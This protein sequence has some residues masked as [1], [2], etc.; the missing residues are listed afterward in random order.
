MSISKDNPC[1]LRMQIFLLNQENKKLDFVET[2][3]EKDQL[4][5]KEQAR[6]ISEYIFKDIILSNYDKEYKITWEGLYIT[7]EFYNHESIE[8][9][10]SIVSMLH[11]NAKTTYLS[12]DVTVYKN[13]PVIFDNIMYICN[14]RLGIIHQETTNYVDYWKFALERPVIKEWDLWSDSKEEKNISISIRHN[15][16][17]IPFA[18]E[19][20]TPANTIY[21]DWGDK[22]VAVNNK[23]GFTVGDIVIA[24][25]KLITQDYETEIPDLFEDNEIGS[26][27]T[28]YFNTRT[29]H[30]FIS[31]TFD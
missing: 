1:E 20:V 26:I 10:D 14:R 31:V 19:V 12:E 29:K 11:N 5:L 21:L 17:A 28:L 24:F 22:T 15:T 25:Q 30:A 18:K 9:I 2:V 4:T 7:I 13:Y 27:D 23:N 6:E 16:E 8:F 3:P